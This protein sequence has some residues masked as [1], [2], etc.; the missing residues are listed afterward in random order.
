MLFYVHNWRTWKTLSQPPNFTCSFCQFQANHGRTIDWS[1]HILSANIENLFVARASIF[2][3]FIIPSTEY[4]DLRQIN[5]IE[6]FAQINF[7]EF[8]KIFSN[9]YLMLWCIPNECWCYSRKKKTS[10][11]KR[12]NHQRT[13]STKVNANKSD[14][15]SF[16]FS[17]SMSR[18]SEL[19]FEFNM[20][21]QKNCNIWIAYGA[22]VSL[23]WTISK[24][25]MPAPSTVAC[26]VLIDYT[27]SLTF[28]SIYY[29]S[30]NIF[31]KQHP[32]NNSVNV[33]EFHANFKWNQ[34]MPV[35]LNSEP[36]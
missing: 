2:D 23:F 4:I 15:R 6:I 33:I 12:F 19:R 31:W 21:I 29:Y 16:Q 36:E 20:L 18:T 24:K 32:K 13:H 8:V 25:N 17:I 34:T 7:S 14:F 22:R 35:N 11:M 1:Q 10:C 3:I 28:L 26:R 9:H 5:S 27:Y 30:F